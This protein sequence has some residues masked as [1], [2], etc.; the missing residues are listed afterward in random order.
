MIFCYST[1]FKGGRFSETAGAMLLDG[2][3][4]DL[5][6]VCKSDC[7]CITTDKAL[8][9]SLEGNA[10]IVPYLPLKMTRQVDTINLSATG[11]KKEPK[12]LTIFQRLA[13]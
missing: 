13:K 2:E 4:N 3:W 10:I 5:L 8:D 1:A 11:S 7:L 6:T 12:L 9:N